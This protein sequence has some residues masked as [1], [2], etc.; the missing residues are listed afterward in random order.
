M[1]L[2][3]LQKKISGKRQELG[4]RYAEVPDIET[5]IRADLFGN[6]KSLQTMRENENAKIKELFEFDKGLATT[7]QSPV[8]GFV[9]DP[10]SVARY[11]QQQ[12]RERAGELADVQKGIANR[13]DVLGDALERAMKLANYGL[14]AKRLEIQALQDEFDDQL[15]LEELRLR[16][17]ESGNSNFLPDFMKSI[18]NFQE[19]AE[20]VKP[21]KTGRT[22]TRATTPDERRALVKRIQAQYPG[23]Q[24][25]YTYNKDGTISYA[26][27]KPDQQYADNN[28]A[29][30]YENQQDT[31]QKILA[32][33]I[34]SNPKQSSDAVNIF[35]L[36]TPQE[37]DVFGYSQWEVQAGVAGKPKTADNVKKAQNYLDS[38]DYIRVRVKKTGET[39]KIPPDEFDASIYERL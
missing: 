12:L 31:L 26:V 14:E 29:S 6:D 39:G 15:K 16:K 1:D 27:L 7:Y 34:A 20:A 32:A 13:R 8:P 11:G 4:Q 23:Q 36:I 22:V 18:L 24:L 5:R 19:K 10:S 17:Q 9:D 30:L 38:Q 37:P 33:G 28:E 3:E 21:Q 35:K 25:S 2:E